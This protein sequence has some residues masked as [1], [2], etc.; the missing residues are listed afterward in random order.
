MKQT[1][2]VPFNDEVPNTWSFTATV[3]VS[4]LSDSW[5][6]LCLYLYDLY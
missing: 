3:S 6:Q 1:A 5:A 2:Q 4:S